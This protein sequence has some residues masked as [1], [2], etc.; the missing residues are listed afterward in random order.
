MSEINEVKLFKTEFMVVEDEAIDKLI[1]LNNRNSKLSTAERLIVRALEY[2]KNHPDGQFVIT[3]S[4]AR[5]GHLELESKL[6][7]YNKILCYKNFEND[8]EYSMIAGDYKDDICQK[9]IKEK[10]PDN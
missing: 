6:M 7:A 5:I 4:P 2:L 9:S 8:A 10:I 1:L 3:N